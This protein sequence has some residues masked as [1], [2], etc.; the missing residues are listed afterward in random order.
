MS[1]I[2]SLSYTTDPALATTSAVEHAT[3]M[4]RS[5]PQTM[6]GGFWEAYLPFRQRLDEQALEIDVDLIFDQVR[7]QTTG[8]AA[9]W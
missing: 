2:S 6:L 1:E 7:V 8:H 3:L 5:C 9:S 4:Q